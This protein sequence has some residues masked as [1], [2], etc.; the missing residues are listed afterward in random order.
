MPAAPEGCNGLDDDC[1]GRTDE[2]NPGGGGQCDSGSRAL[3][4]RPR[5]LHRRAARLP[6][7]QRGHRRALQRPGR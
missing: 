3:R 4:L 2:D 5:V 7:C 6:G 1:D